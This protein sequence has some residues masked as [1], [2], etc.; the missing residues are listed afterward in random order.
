MARNQGLDD[1]D[2]ASVIE[3]LRQQAGR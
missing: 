1:A 3:A 2:F